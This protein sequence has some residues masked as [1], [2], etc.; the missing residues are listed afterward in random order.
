MTDLDI[1]TVGGNGSFEDVIAAAPPEIQ[2]LARAARELL[3]DVMP[4]ITEVP[5][6]RQKIAGYGVGP[7]KMS[8]HFCYIAPFKKHLNFGFMYGAHLP[9][10]QKLLEGKGADL[11][12]VK[13]RKAA[14]LEDAGLREL[15]AEASRYLPKLK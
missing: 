13:I 11:R 15:V 6:A 1:K 4:G 5:W 3:A 8:Q 2:A 7:K 14:E 12:H 10:P 9:D